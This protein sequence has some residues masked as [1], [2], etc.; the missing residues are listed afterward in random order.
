MLLRLGKCSF[1]ATFESPT[2]EQWSTGPRK[3][4]TPAVPLFCVKLAGH[5]QTTLQGRSKA[6]FGR[7]QYSSA[8]LEATDRDAWFDALVMGFQHPTN[9][10]ID[11]MLKCR[12]HCC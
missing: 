9:R 7:D 4:F 12:D 2:L 3:T 10:Y 5:A 6:R 11:Q 8:L 1:Y